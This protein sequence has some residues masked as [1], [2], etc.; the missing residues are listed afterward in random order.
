[1]N[2]KKSKQIRIL[3]V[4]SVLMVIVFS[5]TQCKNTTKGAKEDLKN[6]ETK[7]KNETSKLENESKASITKDKMYFDY[8]MEHAK[9]LLDLDDAKVHFILFN[10]KLKAESDLNKA[11]KHLSNLE[12]STDTDYQQFISKMKAD[13][14]ATKQSIKK[15]DKTA[16]TKLEN[17]SKSFSSEISKLD[18]KM[19]SEKTNISNDDK[20]HFAELRA[21]DY[22]LKAKLASDKKETY[23][24][25]NDYLDKADQE[26][27]KAKQYGDDKYK[28]TIEDLRTD[29][30]SAK[31]SLQAKEKNAKKAVNH[32]MTKLGGF[33]EQM[34]ID[35]PYIAIP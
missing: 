25:A 28:V 9:V 5:F 16:K 1:M 34:N 24:K 14:T 4:L 30:K 35:Y 2:F 22:L 15:D 32:I 31:K 17:L 7:T 23:A 19:S 33:S 3:S 27:V 13:I 8:K 12:N 29:I 20:R 10:D 18:N 21:K 26:Y 6:V 11:E